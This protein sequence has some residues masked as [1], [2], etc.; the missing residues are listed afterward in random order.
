M[1]RLNVVVKLIGGK[2]EE[3]IAVDS[4]STVV[5]LKN[6]VS[7]LFGGA[8]VSAQKLMFS[9]RPLSDECTLESYGIKDGGKINLVLSKTATATADDPV[10]SA[11]VSELQI[12]LRP[13]F[14]AAD[15]QKIIRSFQMTLRSAARKMSLDDIER[16]AKKSAS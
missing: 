5:E 3:T 7:E 10:S 13:H 1:T 8:P 16:F 9:G 2:N 11:L 6:R 15:C 4:T 12:F 14:A